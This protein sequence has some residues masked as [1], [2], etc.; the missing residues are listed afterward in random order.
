VGEGE[1]GSRIFDSRQR[2]LA[3]LP[4][5][6]DPEH[7]GGR[8][9]RLYVCGITPYESGHLGHAFTFC[10]FDVLIRWAEAQGIRVK[11]VQNVTDVDDPLFERAQRDGVAWDALAR[12]QVDV[13][14]RDMSDLGWRRPDVM[15][16]VSNEVEGVIGAVAELCDAGYAYRTD[17]V[18]FDVTRAL[19]YGGLSHRSRISMLRKLRDEGLLGEVSP[20]AKRN[21]LDF[22][23]WRPSAP[24]EPSWQAPFGPGRPG[25]HIECSVMARRHLGAQIEIHGG[26]RDLIFSHHESE[27]AQS[28]ALNHGLTFAQA[29]MHAG[30]VRYEGH[31]MSKSLGNLVLVPQLLE[32]VTPAAARLCLAQH[33]YRRDWTFRWDLLDRVDAL[34][35][36]LAALLG[37]ETAGHPE[38]PA[39]ALA[40]EFALALDDDLDTSRAVRVLSRAV[41]AGDEASARW[42]TSILCGDAALS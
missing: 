39:T 8:L 1:G 37:T 27:R 31:K 4:T 33:H 38:R 22:P 20:G 19:D 7:A 23:L 12:S 41:A 28:E 18:Y 29:W 17:A 21:A 16:W 11:Y 34:A 9:L 24:G 30:M 13:L 26:G 2:A 6:G 10:S 5:T 32:R 14:L 40:D 15:P 25:W 42:M 36:R 35:G 3:P